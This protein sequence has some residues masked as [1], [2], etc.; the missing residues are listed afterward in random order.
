MKKTVAKAMVTDD[1][2]AQMV[3]SIST[4]LLNQTTDKKSEIIE[5]NKLLADLESKKSQ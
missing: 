2:S 1:K 3:G 5:F 4:S